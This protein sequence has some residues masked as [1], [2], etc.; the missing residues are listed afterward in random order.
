MATTIA[1]GIDAEH[2]NSNMVMVT[3]TTNAACCTSIDAEHN[4]NKRIVVRRYESSRK[5]AYR[6]K[7]KIEKA[8]SS[9]QNRSHLSV[10]KRQQVSRAIVNFFREHTNGLDNETKSKIFQGVMHDPFMRGFCAQQIFSRPSRAS[11]VIR[12]KGDPPIFEKAKEL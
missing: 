11:S 3:A 8:K 10:A 5:Q 9:G 2:S 1:A 6:L 7:L 12:S 4:N